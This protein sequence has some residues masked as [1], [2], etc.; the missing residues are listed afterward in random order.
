MSKWN[1]NKN[2]FLSN[3][4]VKNLYISCKINVKYK[5]VYTLGVIIYLNVSTY[6]FFVIYCIIKIR[7]FE[8]KHFKKNNMFAYNLRGI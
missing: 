8:E 6:P 1:N 3:V 7:I 5:S 4:P 2:I